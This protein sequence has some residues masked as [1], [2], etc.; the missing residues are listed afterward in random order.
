MKY[1]IVVL[2]TLMLISGAVH[3]A[4]QTK[5]V[6]ASLEFKDVDIQKAFETLSGEYQVTILGD[7]SVKGKVNSNFIA[8]TLD[9][10]LDAICAVNKLVWLKAYA[11]PDADGKFSATKLFKQFDELKELEASSVIFVDPKVKSQLIFMP[12]VGT[13]TM[14][15]PSSASSAKLKEVY[16]VRAQP[17]PAAVKA[18][19]EK[20]EQEKQ[21]SAQQQAAN[22]AAITPPSDPVA[23]ADHVWNYFNQMSDDQR[24]QVMR[25]LGQRMWNNLPP[26]QQERMRERWGRG[27]GGN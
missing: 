4:D 11:S 1:F 3:A 21:Q 27:N 24:R 10:A 22:Q 25:E 5:P 2:C 6:K 13:D 23:A 17:D 18:E 9:Q 20:A 14:N 16:L 19:K 15:A 7:T 12:A 26:E 8:A